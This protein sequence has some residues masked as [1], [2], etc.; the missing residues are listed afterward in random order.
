MIILQLGGWV[1]FSCILMS[2]IEHQI[3]RKL[4]HRAN[5]L[6]A[7]TASFKRIFEAHALVHHKHYSEIFSDEPVARGEDKEIRLTVRKAPIK[8]IPFA[9]LIAFVSW[10]G[11]AIFVAAFDF[12]SL[13]MEQ[14]SSGDA[15][16]GAEGLQHLAG[17]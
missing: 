14:N 2:F 7:R 4:M 8:A 10:E 17:L 5:F 15:Q 12:S 1:I 9:V 16:A 6:S 3:H 11:A 13:G